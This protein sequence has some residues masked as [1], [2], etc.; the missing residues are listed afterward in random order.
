MYSYYLGSLLRFSFIKY[1]KKY[2]TILQV[3]QF[4][5]LYLNLYFY[6]PPIISEFK[7]F[8]IKIAALYGTGLI[9]LFGNYYIHTYHEK[10]SHQIKMY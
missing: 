9:I 2:I 1:I 4:F 5:A 8:I 6:K 10:K 7:Y 3:C